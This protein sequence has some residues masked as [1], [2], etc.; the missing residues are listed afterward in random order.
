MSKDSIQFA[1]TA[2]FRVETL[3]IGVVGFC[4]SVQVAAVDDNVVRL[5]H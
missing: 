4:G 1:G 3:M 5:E 2:A